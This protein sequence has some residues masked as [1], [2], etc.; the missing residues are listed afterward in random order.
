MPSLLVLPKQLALSSGGVALPG[1]KLYAYQTGTST[2]QN[3]YQDIGLTTPHA[4]PVVADAAGFLAPIYLDPSLPAYRLKL[5]DSNDV[6]VWQFDDVPSNQNIS[7]QFRLKAT[8][9]SLTFEETDASANNGIWRLKVNGEQLLLTI[10]DDAEGTETTVFTFDRAGTTPGDFNFAGQYLKVQGLTT[11]TQE[12]ASYDT[13]TLTGVDSTVTGSVTLRRTGT[14]VTLILP[15]LSGTSN[16][17][18]MT[19]TGLTGLNTST[20]GVLLCRV[21]DNGTTQLGI[22]TVGSSTLTFG[23]GAAGGAFTNSGTKGIPAQTI[24]FDTDIAST[25]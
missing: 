5:T 11:A 20:G 2:P 18:S 12:N 1:A 13:V 22:V 10:L 8:A 15:A 21:T 6:Q 3:T 14:K 23:V 17:T 4:N 24:I 7:Q 16:S 19:I 9:P 25:A